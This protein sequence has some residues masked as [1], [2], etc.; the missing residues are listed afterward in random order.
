MAQHQLHKNKNNLTIHQMNIK[1][2]LAITVMALAVF[3][4]CE[5]ED[6]V[7]KSSEKQMKEFFIVSDSKKI[8]GTIHQESSIIDVEVPYSTDVSSL[9]TELVI[10]DKA[11]VKPNSGVVQDFTSP[12]TYMVSAED[13]STATYKVSVTVANIKNAD[14]L[15]FTV[16]GMQ[17]DINQEEKTITLTLPHTAEISNLKPVL[18]ISEGASVNRN[19]AV[20][21]NFTETV[22]YT[23]TNSDG[24]TKSYQVTINKAQSTEN[25]ILSF[26]FGQFSPA[27]ECVIDNS[28]NTIKAV[29]PWDAEFDIYDMTPTLTISDNATVKPSNNTSQSFKVE[30]EYTVTA[31]DATTRTYKVNVKVED[32]PAATVHPLSITQYGKGSELTITGT[33]LTKC[34][35]TASNESGSF[36][37]NAESQTKTEVVFELPSYSSFTVGEYKLVMKVRDTEFDMGKVTIVPPAPTISSMSTSFD[38][39]E[40]NN[41]LTIN[42]DYFNE[43]ANEVYFVNSQGTSYAPYLKSENDYRIKAAVPHLIPTGDYFIKVKSQGGEVTSTTTI[44]VTQNTT[45]DLIISGVD[46]KTVQ[47]GE[48]LTIYGKNFEEGISYVGFMDGVSATKSITGVR[49]DDETYELTIPSDFKTG[50]FDVFIWGFDSIGSNQYY[51]LQINE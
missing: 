13:G 47:R 48:K 15:G 42:G 37:L 34:T 30:K 35:V 38:S 7:I 5:K 41:I 28:T 14:I 18:T 36:I 6:E 40:G 32:A 20:E 4:A 31:E 10:S 44:A 27:I 39:F 3:T 16:D 45:T 21:V 24:H 12:V 33:N 25:N 23:V 9:I 2:L 51:N 50:N 22:I 29:I 26:V 49:I 1:K 8:E 46:K 11:T 43:E 17:G 19:S